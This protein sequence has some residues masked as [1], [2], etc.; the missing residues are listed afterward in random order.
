MFVPKNKRMTKK[1]KNVLEVDDGDSD[2]RSYLSMPIIHD[3]GTL[4]LNKFSDFLTYVDLPILKTEF[5]GLFTPFL[6]S[7][8]VV[9]E[10]EDLLR[11]METTEKTK[12]KHMH[13]ID[14]ARRK[15]EDLWFAG[16]MA[17]K[18]LKSI[19]SSTVTIVNNLPVTLLAKTPGCEVIV[20]SVENGWEPVAAKDMYTWFNKKI[21]NDIRACEKLPRLNLTTRVTSEVRR[22]SSLDPKWS[23]EVSSS[24]ELWDPR[25]VLV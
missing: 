7:L 17:M 10:D 11:W 14:K 6:I 16:D 4:I 24:V 23:G 3:T 12:A 13:R 5:T 8:A 22:S 19:C 21:G 15:S 25:K 1:P 18:V 2:I 9:C 20:P